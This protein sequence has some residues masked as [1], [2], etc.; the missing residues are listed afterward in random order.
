[1]NKQVVGEVFM[2]GQRVRI[3]REEAAL[4]QFAIHYLGSW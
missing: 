4:H 1:M 2:D 3:G